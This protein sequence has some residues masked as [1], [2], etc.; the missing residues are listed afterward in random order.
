M[1]PLSLRSHNLFLPALEAVAP[2][3][4]PYVSGAVQLLTQ[5]SVSLMEFARYFAAVTVDK[6]NKRTS[7]NNVQYLV[8]CVHDVQLSHVFAHVAAATQDQTIASNYVAAL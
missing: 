4:Q 6:Y 1:D 7:D 3:F 2:E 8:L 5:L